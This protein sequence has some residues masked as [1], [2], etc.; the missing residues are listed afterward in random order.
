MRLNV[1][2]GMAIVAVA[3]IVVEATTIV[4]TAVIRNEPV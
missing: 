4:V 3:A 1:E 2:M